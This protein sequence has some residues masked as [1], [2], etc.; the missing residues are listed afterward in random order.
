MR[1]KNA[2][3]FCASLIL[4]HFLSPLS[5]AD[6]PPAVFHVARVFDGDTLDVDQDR[7][8][9]LL[10][11]D[12]PEAVYKGK[13]Y[14]DAKKEG[15]SIYAMMARGKK[16]KIF[17]RGLVQDKIVRLEFDAQQKDKY[18]NLLAYVF[19]EDGTFVNAELI[20]VG[21]AEARDYPP[22]TK[23]HEFFLKLEEEAKANHLGFWK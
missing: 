7:R 23:Y 13:L 21:Y 12:C 10:G 17:T 19:L 9:H 6:T 15:I 3:T 2:V 16:A 22:N 14:Q 8:V 18:G 11:I 5:F 4:S 1:K 20:R